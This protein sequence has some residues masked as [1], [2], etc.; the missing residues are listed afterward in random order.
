MG[1]GLELLL[2]AKDRAFRPRMRGW[3]AQ[4]K[5]EEERLDV[6]LTDA[7]VEGIK[8]ARQLIPWSSANGCVGGGSPT[9]AGK[10]AFLFR[11][12]CVGGGPCVSHDGTVVRFR[13]RTHG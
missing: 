1:G 12:G 13:P 3:R 6:P 10:A 5:Q 2:H 11:H 4:R 9:R 8:L 7:W